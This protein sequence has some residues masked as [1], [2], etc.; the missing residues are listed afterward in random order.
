MKGETGFNGKTFLPA[1][2]SAKLYLTLAIHPQAETM[3]STSMSTLQSRT[4]IDLT[5]PYAQLHSD[6]MC[7]PPTLIPICEST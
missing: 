6:E 7:I 4:Q 2:V 5:L 1:L 3:N